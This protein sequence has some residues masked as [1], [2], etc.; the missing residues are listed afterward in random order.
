MFNTPVLGNANLKNELELTW[1][2][3][4]TVFLTFISKQEIYK[5]LFVCY[6]EKE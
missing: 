3:G 2:E 5:F 1:E 4:I 6:A